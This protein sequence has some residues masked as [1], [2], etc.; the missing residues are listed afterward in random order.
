MAF[1]TQFGDRVLF[2][3]DFNLHNGMWGSLHD[4]PAGK[5]LVEALEESDFV[6]LNNG[7]PTYYGVTQDKDSAIDLTIAHSSMTARFSWQVNDYLWGSDHF[8]IIIKSGQFFREEIRHR[9]PPRLYTTR[10]NW[11]S[12]QLIMDQRIKEDWKSVPTEIEIAYPT[13]I[14]LVEGALSESTPGFHN[15]NVRGSTPQGKP[16]EG[17]GSGSPPC[18]W[19]NVECEMLIRQRKAALN[20][21]QLTRLF[22]DLVKYQRQVAITKRELRR[23]KRDNFRRFCEGI[24]K[25]TNQAFLWRT[26]KSFHSRCNQENTNQE[27]DTRKIERV[28]EG[29][30]SL[31]PPWVPR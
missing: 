14:C 1:L 21:F 16:G 24:N 20:N 2:G 5:H 25:Y 12:F 15:R 11:K 29:F 31:C 27:Y 22:S 4:C 3:G 19:W 9:R 8:P 18:P 17:R 26:I 6:T 30:Y 28:K 10:T 13:F 23:I 7:S